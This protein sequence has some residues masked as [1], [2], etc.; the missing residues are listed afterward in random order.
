VK[1]RRIFERFEVDFPL[2]Y[3]DLKYNREGTGRLINISAGGGGMIVTDQQ[4]EYATPLEMQ[5]YI[6]DIKEPLRAQGKVAWS[7]MVEPTVYRAGVEF[8]KV[9]FMDISRIL[10]TIRTKDKYPE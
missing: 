1:E 3:I 10:R 8:D 6:P 2:K 9:D 4:L 7:T 5:F